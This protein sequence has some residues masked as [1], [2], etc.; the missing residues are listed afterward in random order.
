MPMKDAEFVWTG[1]AFVSL[2]LVSEMKLADEI[3]GLNN[4]FLSNSLLWQAIYS[5][6]LIEEEIKCVS[7]SFV[8]RESHG[9]KYRI[10]NCCK[11]FA[12]LVRNAVLPKHFLL[13]LQRTKMTAASWC[14]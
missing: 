8:L 3:E 14:A 5:S 10:C 9:T 13:L 7:R 2:N 1:Q 12:P 4:S 11:V 6:S